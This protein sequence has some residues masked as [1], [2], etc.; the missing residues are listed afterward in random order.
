MYILKSMDA[1]SSTV[2]KYAL[3]EI[4]LD[5]VDGLLVFQPTFEEGDNDGFLTVIDNLIQDISN[6]AVVIPKV[7]STSTNLHYHSK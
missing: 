5:L 1:S 7:W 6:V 4:K 3:F 2:N